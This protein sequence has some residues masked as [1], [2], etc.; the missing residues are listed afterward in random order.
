MSWD[1][2]RSIWVEGPIHGTKIMYVLCVCRIFLNHTIPELLESEMIPLSGSLM[3]KVLTW[4]FLCI[5]YPTGMN[6]AVHC[7]EMVQKICADEHL[8][9]CFKQHAI[10]WLK[11][12]TEKDWQTAI[13]YN[14]GRLAL[15][16]NLHHAFGQFIEEQLRQPIARL[17]YILEKGSAL[18]SYFN[19][20]NTKKHYW[21]MM[22]MDPS[23]INLEI[24]PIPVHPEGYN[25][26]MPL[27]L[28]LPFSPLYANHVENKFRELYQVRCMTQNKQ[29][30][31]SLL[32]FPI[33]IG[34]DIKV[35]MDE[36][37][38]LI[39][40]CIE[41]NLEDYVSDFAKIYVPYKSD[42]MHASETKIFEWI[43]R[44][45]FAG[46]IQSPGFEMHTLMW[47]KGT[48]LVAQTHLVAT[49]FPMEYIVNEL[50][51]IKRHKSPKK[52]F[53][54]TLVFECCK[55]ILPT[56]QVIQQAGGIHSWT[57]QINISIKLASSLAA[58]SK[59]PNH[60]LLMLMLCT[61]RDFA[62]I[63][64]IPLASTIESLESL[65]KW[66]IDHDM[67]YS[68][69]SLIE[70]VL[71]MTLDIN[72][73]KDD[74]P[75]RAIWFRFLASFFNQLFEIQILITS[76]EISRMAYFL[77]DCIAPTCS[78]KNNMLRIVQ[79][80]WSCTIGGVIDHEPRCPQFMNG[81]CTLFVNGGYW[82]TNQ[83]YILLGDAIYEA[84]QPTIIDK[85]MLG[86][87][88][89][90]WAY[91]AFVKR[92]SE[93]KDE[94]VGNVPLSIHVVCSIALVR[95]TLDF[96]AKELFV[97][98]GNK[99]TNLHHLQVGNNIAR[100][101]HDGFGN[102]GSPYI[103]ALKQYL[104]K[105]LKVHY[106]MSI[107]DVSHLA[108][109]CQRNKALET[110]ACMFDWEMLKEVT[111]P[112][113]FNPFNLASSSS[114]SSTSFESVSKTLWDMIYS[115]D[116]N[117][118]T[119][120]KKA[121]MLEQ[122]HI[123]TTIASELYLVQAIRELSPQE[124]SGTQW[125]INANNLQSWLPKW[126]E[127]IRI[128]LGT[129]FMVLRPE[130]DTYELRFKVLLAHVLLVVTSLPSDSPLQGYMT[131]QNSHLQEAF[132]LTCPNSL[133]A[134][135]RGPLL[136]KE[137]LAEYKCKCGYIYTIG[138]CTRPASIAKCPECKEP[139]GGQH[140]N[141]VS[142]NKELSI[143]NADEGVYNILQLVLPFGFICIIGGEAMHECLCVLTIF[144]KMQAI[145]WIVKHRMTNFTKCE[146]WIIKAIEHSELLF[147]IAF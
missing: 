23:I 4:S 83:P 146:A 57:H 100:I 29:E 60:E 46:P 63:V 112:L 86:E 16:S 85:L 125:L 98:H 35:S 9:K 119:L 107:L 113:G 36:S 52:N 140:H 92:L 137:K 41:I 93:A 127:A 73:F 69:L 94:L 114:S 26:K 134:A 49:C 58:G 136:V 21:H 89:E 121:N 17:I 110:Y 38:K 11:V 82:K 22:V 120:I 67:V 45:N 96:V 54:Q 124:I 8:L 109:K 142:G 84:I 42:E 55:R 108:F 12:N 72:S 74:E 66:F 78:M 68:P 131:L 20:D 33:N 102:C 143:N 24:V 77:F 135:L 133:I 62:T 144:F 88:T 90:D 101:L 13:V 116:E 40:N 147:I 103:L 32:T 106:G 3:V 64:I 139:I 7:Q 75:Q 97:V 65:A 6:S 31:N 132:V 47:E 105:V 80:S 19:M 27:H 70:R 1:F 95:A 130:M 111:N 145:L 123:T 43:L 87:N 25:I 61:L 50:A 59:G 129:Q 76:K 28:L 138:N 5:K 56:K 126:R 2:L 48:R 39:F 34:Q 71:N 14:R 18:G 141:L 117:P 81:Y 10:Q 53:D 30:Q 15:T 104:L 99:H 51:E 118:R 79:A 122:A 37:M 91:E 128:F 44:E 115:Q